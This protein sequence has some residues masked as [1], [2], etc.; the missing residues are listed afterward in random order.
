MKSLLFHKLHV[1]VSLSVAKLTFFLVNW[2]YNVPF[3]SPHSK[4]R[5]TNLQFNWFSLSRLRFWQITLLKVFASMNE[6][7]NRQAICTPNSSPR[8]KSAQEIFVSTHLVYPYSIPHIDVVQLFRYKISVF[9]ILRD[10][11]HDLLCS[12]YVKTQDWLVD[13]CTCNIKL[14]PLYFH[15]GLWNHRETC[16]SI[17]Y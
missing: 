8:M 6:E 11:L 2:L 1:T 17:I 14:L 5:T 4:C 12:C 7:S 13:L 15:E 9:I 3:D 10:C 16:H